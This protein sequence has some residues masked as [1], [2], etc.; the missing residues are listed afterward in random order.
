[1]SRRSQ[2]ERRLESSYPFIHTLHSQF[3]DLD[4]LGHVNNVVVASY[5]EDARAHFLSKRWGGGPRRADQT[6]VLVANVDIDYLGE[7]LHPRPFR[8][9]VGVSRVGTSSLTISKALFMDGECIGL[10]DTTLVN[11]HGGA[12]APITD[13]RRALLNDVMT[14]W[15]AQPTPN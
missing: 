10:A 7:A 12:P 4:P 9:G 2:P 14:T 13:E 1:M 6:Y 15:A 5:Y 3:R 11:M 8:V